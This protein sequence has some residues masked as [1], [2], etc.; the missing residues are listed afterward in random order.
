[1][2]APNKLSV[3]ASIDKNI[4][5][6]MHQQDQRYRHQQLVGHGVKKRPELRGLIHAPRNPAIEPI[7]HGRDNKNDSGTHSGDRLRQVVAHHHQR[8]R[9]DPQS[10]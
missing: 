10:G 8:D 3:N 4:V 9:H 2:K 7:G 6:A 1:M 5:H